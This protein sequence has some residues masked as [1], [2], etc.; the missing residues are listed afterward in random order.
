MSDTLNHMAN[1][2]EC[3]HRMP[4]WPLSISTVIGVTL[5]VPLAAAAAEVLIQGPNP[6]VAVSA[7]DVRAE[8]AA[9]PEGLRAQTIATEGGLA[10]PIN[11]IYRRK[12][13]AGAALAAGLD[14]TDQVAAQ[15]QRSRDD[16]LAT[17]ALNDQ[18]A[19]LL[20]GIPDMAVRA[21]ELYQANPDRY[22]I[23]PRVHVRHILLHAQTEEERTKRA[24]DAA[25]ILERARKGENFAALAKALS[26]DPGSAA[27]GGELPLFQQGQMVK[28]FEDAAFALQQP[29]DLSPVISSQF[30]LHIIQLEDKQPAQA[31]PFDEVKESI[32]AKLRADWVAEALEAW[33]K[34]VVNPAKAAVNKA[35]VDSF[36]AEMAAQKPAAVEA[37]SVPGSPKPGQTPIDR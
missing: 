27:E 12:A 7:A 32:I 1:Q 13:L 4:R 2:M 5:L 3:R 15:L 33:R 31:V 10:V 25:A 11:A 18:R 9:M 30:G 35:A 37:S 6:A 28:E 20:A 8:L 26:E 19:H 22:Q 34:E 16:V 23:P 21:R 29:G 14:Q 17:A 36:M 24:A